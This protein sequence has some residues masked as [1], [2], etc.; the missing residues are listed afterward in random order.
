MVVNWLADMYRENVRCMRHDGLLPPDP[1]GEAPEPIRP[2]QRSVW[3][4]VDWLIPD[5]TVI[6]DEHLPEG[7]KPYGCELMGLRPERPLTAQKN[8][9]HD[10][11]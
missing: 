9:G 8:D 2:V 1:E 5:G 10:G 11:D 4:K 6:D 7:L 3:P